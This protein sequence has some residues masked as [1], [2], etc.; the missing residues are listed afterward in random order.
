M[1]KAE[2]TATLAHLLSFEERDDVARHLKR[3]HGIDNA[4]ASPLDH[5]E[6]DQVH[7]LEHRSRSIVGSSS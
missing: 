6:L 3:A 5:R 7:L 4:D 1:N 2:R